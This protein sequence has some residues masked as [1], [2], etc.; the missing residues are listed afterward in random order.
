MKKEDLKNL[1][2]P[3]LVFLDKEWDSK[4]EVLENLIDALVSNG[5]VT[6]KKVFI[7]DVFE[8]EKLTPTGFEGGLAIPHG[9][10]KAVVKPVFAFAKLSGSVDNWESVDPDNKVK[11]VFLLAI[12]DDKAG[13]THLKILSTLSASLMD[14]EYFANLISATT[15]ED[16]LSRLG[17][18][19][20]NKSKGTK[21]VMKKIVAISN[22]PAGIAHTYMVAEQL[23]KKGKAAQMEVRVETQGANGVEDKLTAQEIKNADYVILAIG[24]GISEDDR[25]RFAG[26]KVIH[27]PVSEALKN[28]DAVLSDL[29]GKSKKFAAYS[30]DADDNAEDSKGG[31]YEHLMNGVSFMI[32]FVV[33]GGLLLSISTVLMQL[34]PGEET[35]IYEMAKMIET[36]G[37]YGFQFMVPILGAYIAYSIADKPGL[38]PAFILSWMANDKALLG[39]ESGAGFFGAIIVGIGIGYFVK[40][41]R[42]IKVGKTIQ[43]LMGFLIIPFVATL[44]G[45]FFVYYLIGPVIGGI[46]AGMTQFLANSAGASAMITAMIIG[47]MICF[48]AGGPINKTA[49]LF[50][51][52][53]VA[54]GIFSFFGVVAV[55]VIVPTLSAGIATR[56]RPSLFSDFERENGIAAMI[57]SMF[58][59]SE[60][61]I[62]YI[63]NDPKALIPANLITGAYIGLAVMITGVERISP[64][65]GIIEPFLGITTPAWA[66]Y[67]CIIT[68]TILNVALII[69][70]KST[71]GKNNAKQTT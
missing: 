39:T 54:E 9:K 12:P 18:K 4:E 35:A 49:Y 23:K 48:D 2:N 24:R 63:V 19:K 8:R 69:I 68:A 3:N 36:V 26:K 22:C 6:D 37:V 16:F 1:T 42:S 60:P 28:I 32:P 13:S 40:W 25:K 34:F 30:G 61:G 47:M 7:N 55:A 17:G 20:T 71:F 44:I 70:F 53:L 62:P 5:Y 43:P 15:P 50:A 57:S 56:V 11:Y 65:P 52:G 45:S 27:I 64:G 51:L 41:M 67:F 14:E 46:M 31:I 21:Q 29:E 59:I 66:F 33:A 38:A 10:S 58:G